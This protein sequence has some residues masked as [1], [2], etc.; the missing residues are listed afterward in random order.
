MPLSE[1]HPLFYLR[2]GIRRKVFIGIS[3]VIAGLL[4]GVWVSGKWREYDFWKSTGPLLYSQTWFE[5]R[6]RAVEAALP[7]DRKSSARLSDELEA[8]L[9]EELYRYVYSIV[10]YKCNEP[11]RLGGLGPYEGGYDICTDGTFNLTP[12]C[13]VYS[14]GIGYI[15]TFDDDVTKK[16]FCKDL[17][18]DPSMGVKDHN[19]SELI[20]FF[21]VGIGGV[22][23]VNNKNWKIRTY[24]EL[25][26]ENGHEKS[27]VDVLKIDVEHAEW[28]SL[29]YVLSQPAPSAL[30]RVKQL[31]IEIH[32][33]DAW[34]PATASTA[35]L[36]MYWRILLGIRRLGFRAWKIH[37]APF[38]PSHYYSRRRQQL[39]NKLVSCFEILFVN[40]NFA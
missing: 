16:F 8:K 21:N 39:P 10:D 15:W 28:E 34:R 1:H 33:R 31:L 38:P 29:V 19:R 9:E 22:N 5:D 35:D 6:L 23:G 11:V 17:A 32:F 2:C 26:K 13:L 20:S 14:F 40:T 30:S 7:D 4:V 36:V 12:P 18:Y 25:L 37:E 3:L 27:I 24:N